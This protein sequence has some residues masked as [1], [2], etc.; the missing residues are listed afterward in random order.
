M[1]SSAEITSPRSGSFVAWTI[2]ASATCMG[3]LAAFVLVSSMPEPLMAAA[4]DRRIAA[5]AVL[6]GTLALG[7]PLQLLWTTRKNYVYC[8]PREIL[9]RERDPLMFFVWCALHLL[10]A[11]AAGIGASVAFQLR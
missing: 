10:F 3:L 8:G 6:L 2:F 1:F 5:G 11:I 4:P 9:R 7:I